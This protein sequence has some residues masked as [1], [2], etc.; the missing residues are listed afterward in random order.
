MNIYDIY[1]PADLERGHFT[2][3]DHEIKITDLPERFQ[4]RS[5]P[6]EKAD[7]VELEEEAAWIYQQAFATKPISYQVT[8]EFGTN[9]RTCQESNF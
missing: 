3:R 7:D 8:H 9:S 5:L 4:L 1:E 6:I 2:S